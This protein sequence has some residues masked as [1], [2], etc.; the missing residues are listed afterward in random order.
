[1]ADVLVKEC[2]RMTLGTGRKM[3]VVHKYSELS[4]I[5]E[6]EEVHSP[7]PKQ[8]GYRDQNADQTRLVFAP[9]EAHLSAGSG[10]QD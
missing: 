9:S 7:A 10:P 4:P 6:K 2:H 1:M 5:W 3:N 8:Q